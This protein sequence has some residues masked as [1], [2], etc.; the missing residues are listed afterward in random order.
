M[1]NMA[2]NVYI[3]KYLKAIGHETPEVEQ[4]AIRNIG[5]GIFNELLMPHSV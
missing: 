3:L 2:T 4:E 1:I 5:N